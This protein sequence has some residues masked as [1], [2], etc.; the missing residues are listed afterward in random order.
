MKKYLLVLCVI[1]ILSYVAACAPVQ[2]VTSPVP[3]PVAKP[4]AKKPVEEPAAMPPVQSISADVKGVL[5]NSNKVKSIYYKY[6]GPQTGNNFFEFYIKGNKIKYLPAREIKSLDKPE[7]YDS[8][9]IDKEAITAQS[10][11]EAAYCAYKGKK[12]DLD[13]DEAYIL[14][15]FDWIDGLTSATKVGEEVIDDRS[16]W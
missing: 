16:T 6:R 5:G 14:N 10:Y 8:I 12:G 4:E 1:V 7:S 15:V 11:C 9:F 3:P 2:Q 13:Y